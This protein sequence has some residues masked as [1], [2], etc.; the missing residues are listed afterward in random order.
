MKRIWTQGLLALAIGTG[1]ALSAPAQA[2]GKTEITVARFFGACDADFGKVVDASKA[3][4]ECG[5]ITALINEYNATNKDNAVVK[6]QIAEWG[7]YYDQLTARL[8]A[9]DVPTISVMHESVLGDYVSRKLV[10][11]LDDGLKAAGVDTAK[12]TE[13]AKRGTTIGGKTYALPMDTWSWLWHIN[14]NLM[15]KA[16]LT[17]A[18]GTPVLPK[19]PDELLA[20]ARKFKAAT[21]KPYFAWANANETAAPFRTFLTLLYQQNGQL[22]EAG[23][24]KINLHSKEATNAIELMNTLYSEGHVKPDT[25]YSGTNQA[26]LNGDA[27]IVVVGTW[28]IDEFMAQAEK[29]GS[30]LHGAYSVVPFAK[31]Y[32]KPAVFAD[33]HSWVLLKGGAK[34][35]A[36][37]KAAYGFLKF[38]WDRNYEWAR[39]GHLP[40]NQSVADSDTFKK[41]PFRS[42]ILEITRT[43]VAMPNTIPRQRT[44]ESV[45]GEELASV[46]LSKKPIPQAMKA[47]EDRVNKTLASVK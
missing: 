41:L 42:S 6:P 20:H 34:D 29:P 46:M 2:A 9:K 35:E 15:K 25:D 11:P 36:Q 5:I 12:Y 47:A 7:P 40:A 28:T 13:Q 39:T 30:P 37:R 19:S 22:F 1:L 43:G 27:G 31:L 33:G 8:V 45:V 23:N 16:G 24:K 10:E 44:I 18:D 32:A 14:G 38:L 26:F 4:G 17:Q 21:G 3:R